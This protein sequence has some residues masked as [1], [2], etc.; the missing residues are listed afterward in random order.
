M[1][2]IGDVFERLLTLLL[3][4]TID[5]GCAEVEVRVVREKVRQVGITGQVC[6]RN[7]IGDG[8]CRV[9]LFYIRHE[10]GGVGASF[11]LIVPAGSIRRET[12]A[13]VAIV[14][15][16]QRQPASFVEAHEVPRH[17]ASFLQALQ[18]F[19]HRQMIL[20]QFV[21]H[22][23]CADLRDQAGIRKL[24]LFAERLPEILIGSLVLCIERGEF[25]LGLR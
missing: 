18:S 22:K 1:L 11:L 10:R 17:V 15:G 24:G 13:L 9:S 7:M 12:G 3:E 2:R 8:G 25:C 5:I 21:Q 14:T 4:V 23:G 19:K 16:N 6:L 20:A